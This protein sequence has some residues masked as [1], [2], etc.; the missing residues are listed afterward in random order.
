MP[1]PMEGEFHQ[2]SEETSGR[3]EDVMQKSLHGKRVI[4][5]MSND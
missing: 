1:V 5:P 4:P 3:C 2:V